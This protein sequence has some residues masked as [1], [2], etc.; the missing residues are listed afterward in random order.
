MKTSCLMPALALSACLGLDAAAAPLQKKNVKAAR[1]RAEATLK[2]RKKAPA[3]PSFEERHSAFL[4]QVSEAHANGW[5]PPDPLSQYLVEELVVTGL[6]ETEDGHGAF[7]YAKPSGNTFFASPGAAL[8]NGQFLEVR[9]GRRGYVDDVRLVFSQKA[10][11]KGAE[12]TVLKT[13]EGLEPP[14][15]PEPAPAEPKPPEKPAPDSPGGDTT[16]GPAAPT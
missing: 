16:A 11:P 4:R 2:G 7:F 14:P 5:Q 12:Q 13:V 15:P 1:S 8:Y 10:G 9:L 6:F 3:F